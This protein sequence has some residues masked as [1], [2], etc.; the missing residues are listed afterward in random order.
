[1]SSQWSR[2]RESTS[3]W[4]GVT[5]PTSHGY[6]PTQS[7]ETRSLAADFALVSGSQVSATFWWPALQ[8]LPQVRSP[9][10]SGL[11][12]WEFF[13]AGAAG[14]SSFGWLLWIQAL[15]LLLLVMLRWLGPGWFGALLW[16]C[17]PGALPQTI[18]VAA[19]WRRLGLVLCSLGALGDWF[20]GLWR[21]RTNL[22]GHAPGLIQSL[23]MA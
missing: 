2:A 15:V 16:L 19:G 7:I 4:I 17:S 3:D 22:A 12:L 5:T 20:D 9:I 8:L 6:R 11:F 14:A 13:G 18:G 23:V 1:M 21:F 10:P